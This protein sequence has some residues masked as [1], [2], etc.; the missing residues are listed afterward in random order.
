MASHRPM[1]LRERAASA[2]ARLL[3]AP[4]ETSYTILYFTIPYFTIL[5]LILILVLVLI[6]ILILILKLILILIPTPQLCIDM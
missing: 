4:P 3:R 2:V 5:I 6:L 1:S